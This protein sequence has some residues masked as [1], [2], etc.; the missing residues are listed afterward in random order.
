MET[1]VE[2]VRFSNGEVV[3]KIDVSGRNERYIERCE[4]GI[5]INLNHE[6]YFTRK[7]TTGA[8]K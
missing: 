6:E 7:A 4:A 2:I 1:F 8:T 3:D 5:N